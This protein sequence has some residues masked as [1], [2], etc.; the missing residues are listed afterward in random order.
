MFGDYQEGQARDYSERH[1]RSVQEDEINHM[2][3]DKYGRS[4]RQRYRVRKEMLFHC[5]KLSVNKHHPHA[6]H[7]A[8]ASTNCKSPIPTAPLST[9]FKPVSL[10]RATRSARL[11]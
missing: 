8:A 10:S 6:Q 4:H 5:F 3:G 1:A 11:R 9:M 2:S 7:G